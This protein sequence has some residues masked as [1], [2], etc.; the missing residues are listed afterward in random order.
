MIW[1]QHLIIQTYTAALRVTR[2]GR[3]VSNKDT[4]RAGGV[5][6]CLFVT[7]QVKRNAY[8]ATSKFCFRC[9]KLM[10]EALY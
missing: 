9:C 5:Y 2:G 3:N 7:Q 6:M 1:Y 10:M 8:V 4:Q